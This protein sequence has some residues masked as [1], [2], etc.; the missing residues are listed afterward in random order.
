[1]SGVITYEVI[2]LDWLDSLERWWFSN[3]Y[4]SPDSPGSDWYVG[5]LIAQIHARKTR[6]ISN[7][8]S[9]GCLIIHSFLAFPRIVF[10]GFLFDMPWGFAELLVI[11]LLVIFRTIFN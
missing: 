2:R 8:G 4:K 6:C 3:P 1:V 5:V 7:K 9:I 11:R 10:S